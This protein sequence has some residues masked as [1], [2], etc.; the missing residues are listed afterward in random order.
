VTYEELEALRDVSATISSG[1]CV[2]II[3]PNGAGKS[4]LLKVISRVHRPS[5]GRV[6]VHGSVSP[7][8]ELGLGMNGELT[9]RENVFLQGAMLGFSRAEM[10]RRL[11]RITEFAE[12]EDFL[13][14]PIRTYS[15]GMVARLAF[16]VAT[17]VDPDV[18]IVD[19][20]LSVGDERFQ[21]KCRERMEGFRRAGK[22]VVIVS[23]SLGQIRES[24]GRALWIDHGRLV[25]D[26]D[27]L[28]VTDAYHEWSQL[29]DAAID[30]V[31]FVRERFWTPA[32]AK[33]LSS[34]AP[35]FVR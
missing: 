34:S 11:G 31:E 6:I 3:G 25:A 33:E 19:E 17:D 26:G 21:A 27:T 14:A 7:L 18:L 8:L 15:T 29:S 9:G 23:H 13:D 20:A 1:E 24:C 16:S 35:R 28:Q 30:P 4:T 10:R 5:S 12:L 2:G 22:T 32:Q